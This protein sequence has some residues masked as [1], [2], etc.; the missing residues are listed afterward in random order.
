[1]PSCTPGGHAGCFRQCCRHGLALWLSP[2]LT[3][4]LGGEPALLVVRAP[5]KPYRLA[6]SAWCNAERS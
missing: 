1:M 3:M 5:T 2:A 6:C 4:L